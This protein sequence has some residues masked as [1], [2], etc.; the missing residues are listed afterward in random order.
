MPLRPRDSNGRFVKQ[1]TKINL[2]QKTMEIPIGMITMIILSIFLFIFPWYC[3]IKSWLSNFSGIFKILGDL[4][5]IIAKAAETSSKA[6]P[7]A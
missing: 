4:A 2:S 3:V 1:T 6:T 7:N 5:I